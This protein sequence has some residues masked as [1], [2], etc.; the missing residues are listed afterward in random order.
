MPAS[1]PPESFRLYPYGDDTGFFVV[2]LA[3]SLKEL[4]QTMATHTGGTRTHLVGAVINATSEQISQL[5][6]VVYLAK[7]HMGAGLVGHELAHAAFRAMDR[8][9]LRVDHWS[10]QGDSDLQTS[11]NE[12]EFCLILERLTRQFW[13]EAYGRGFVA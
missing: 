5:L 4:R 2:H 8:R 6:G 1:L 7:D 9:D 3:S 11:D 10:R 13:K 12:E